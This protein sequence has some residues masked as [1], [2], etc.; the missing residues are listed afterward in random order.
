MPLRHALARLGRRRSRRG[1]PLSRR[2]LHA[3]VRVERFRLHRNYRPGV[4]QTPTTIFNAEENAE[5]PGTDSA[6]TWRPVFRDLEVVSTPDPHLD[7]EAVESA[8]RVILDRL[9]ELS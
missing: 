5:T 8:K 4:V 7:D 1:L 2:I 9:Q 3:D 6:A